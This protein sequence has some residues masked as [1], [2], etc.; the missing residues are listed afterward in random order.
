MALHVQEALEMC[1]NCSVGTYDISNWASRAVLHK[2]NFTLSGAK[3]ESLVFQQPLNLKG[4]LNNVTLS[5]DLV[6]TLSDQQEING[7]LSIS[8]LLPDDTLYS[9]EQGRVYQ[10]ATEEFSV[11][12]RFTN[13]QVNGLY[14]GIALRHFYDQAVSYRNRYILH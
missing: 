1:N 9:S 8:S 13:L 11:A 7:R 3:F 6:L 10:Q 12:A 4:T 14:D 5:R 2:G